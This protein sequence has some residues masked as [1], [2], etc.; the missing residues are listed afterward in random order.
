[1]TSGR[2]RNTLAGLG[3]ATANSGR[4]YDATIC[5]IEDHNSCI[6]SHHVV[7]LCK[8]LANAFNYL[9][10]GEHLLAHRIS[11]GAWLAGKTRVQIRD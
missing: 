9:D 1:M 10:D 3:P 7:E 5:R 11:L 6:K 4:P 2:R 8:S